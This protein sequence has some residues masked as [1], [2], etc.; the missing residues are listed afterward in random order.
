MIMKSMTKLM[1]KLHISGE[2]VLYTVSI[3]CFKFHAMMIFNNFVSLNHNKLSKNEQA[4]IS[5]SS[6]LL[7]LLIVFSYLFFD[8]I[9]AIPVLHSEIAIFTT[10]CLLAHIYS[11]ILHF[12]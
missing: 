3:P 5:L 10:N 8:V 1:V 9:L 2:N 4:S 12:L 7:S 11:M 6:L